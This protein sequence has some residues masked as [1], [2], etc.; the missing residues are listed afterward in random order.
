M[1]AVDAL[2][3]HV[4]LSQSTQGK[5]S[6]AKLSNIMGTTAGIWA[7]SLCAML[8]QLCT[9][10]LLGGSLAVVSGAETF[11]GKTR[12]RPQVSGRHVAFT[13]SFI[14]F[15]LSL[16]FSLANSWDLERGQRKLLFGDT[17]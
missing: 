13:L 10:S 3:A 4:Y 5:V 6:V 15:E 7:T 16:H 9:A 8:L 1:C 12:S 11:T 14:S 17:V 2:Q